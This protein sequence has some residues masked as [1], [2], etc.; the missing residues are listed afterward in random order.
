MVPEKARIFLKNCMQRTQHSW[1]SLNDHALT[2][3]EVKLCVSSQLAPSSRETA[4]AVT[5]PTSWAAQTTDHFLLVLEAGL[6]D[7]GVGGAGLQRTPSWACRRPSPPRVLTGSSLSECLCPDH[8]FLQGL[9][10]LDICDHPRDLT[11][12]ASSLHRP[13]GVAKTEHA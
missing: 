12:P 3:R 11:S 5:K 2:E 9:Q 10:S 8:L 6:P 1:Y 13:H 7:P 4:L